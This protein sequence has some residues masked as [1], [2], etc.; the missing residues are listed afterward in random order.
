MRT[1]R[2]SDAIFL[3]RLEKR[4]K[5]PRCRGE[6]MDMQLPERERERLREPVFH[7][8]RGCK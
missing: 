6:E 1:L 4:L 3:N 2:Q 8:K 5:R 7:R